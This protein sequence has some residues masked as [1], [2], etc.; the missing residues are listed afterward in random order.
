MAG[1]VATKAK[2]LHLLEILHTHSDEDHPLDAN[3][4]IAQLE[5]RG[6]SAERKSIYRDIEVLRDYGFDILL[7]KS[8]PSGY[9]LAER[10]F[11]L[12]EIRLLMD[13]VLSAN[14]ITRKKSLQLVEKLQQMCSQHQTDAL[15]RQ[16]YIDKRNKHKNEEIYYSIH[17]INQA[18]EQ[19]KKITF[20]YGRRVL[21]NEGKVTMSYRTFTVSPYA[22]LWYDDCYYVIGNNQKYDNLMHLRLDRMSKVT[23]TKQPSRSFEEVSV[24]RNHFDVADYAAKLSNAFGGQPMTIELLC[25]DDLLEAILDRFGDQISLRNNF[26][27]RFR[28]RTEMAISDGLVRDIIGLGDGVEVVSPSVLREKVALQ[29]KKLCQ[30]YQQD[31]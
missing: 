7:T 5:K 11:E 9:F 13:A 22:L 8:H 6:I 24:Y 29:L 15:K 25:R 28:F 23:M 14:F 16:V 21:S 1:N 17:V 12:A 20:S 18:I 30:V 26:D 31:P 4:L 2:L 3:A 10:K 27:G 19:K